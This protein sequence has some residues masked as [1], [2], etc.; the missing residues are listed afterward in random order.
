MTIPANSDSTDYRQKNA[1]KK[2]INSEI[3]SFQMDC[4]GRGAAQKLII[5]KSFP[6]Q[7]KKWNKLTVVMEHLLEIFKQHFFF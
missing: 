4:R 2:Q 1:T 7:A 6:N 5:L 3:L